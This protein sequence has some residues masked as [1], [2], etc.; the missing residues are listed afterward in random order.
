MAP[1]TAQEAAEYLLTC[2]DPEREDTMT[3]LKLQKLLYYCQGWHLA[4]LDEPMFSDSVEAYKLGPVVPSVY[5]KYK[6]RNDP[7]KPLITPTVRPNVPVKTGL[8]LEDVWD[9]YGK[10]TASGLVDMTHSETPWREAY[11]AKKDHR[12][13][14]QG[15]MRDFF[16]ARL[17][18]TA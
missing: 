14:T 4:L 1:I 7:A 15:S 12:V 3:N 2:I 8:V 11:Q 5:K 9:K 16:K 17:D 10:F 6:D 18:S 13:I